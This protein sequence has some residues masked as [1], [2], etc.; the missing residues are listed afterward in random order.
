MSQQRRRLWHIPFH[1]RANSPARAARHFMKRSDQANYVPSS[2][3]GVPLFWLRILETGS[4]ACL[5]SRLHDPNSR[6]SG[7]R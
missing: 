2:G 5:R 3:G 4:G 7:D 1:R 6:M